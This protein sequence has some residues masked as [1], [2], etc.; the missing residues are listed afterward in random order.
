MWYTRSLVMR[1]LMLHLAHTFCAD[2][3]KVLMAEGSSVERMAAAAGLRIN[4]STSGSIGPFGPLCLAGDEDLRASE[5]PSAPP[6]A[7]LPGLG[8]RNGPYSY[9]RKPAPDVCEPGLSEIGG[10]VEGQLCRS[11]LSGGSGDSV[12]TLTLVTFENALRGSSPGW[13]S[14]RTRLPNGCSKQIRQPLVTSRKYLFV[15]LVLLLLLLVVVVEGIGKLLLLVTLRF[16]QKRPLA[17]DRRVE[18]VEVEVP[19]GDVIRQL[20]VR[21]HQKGDIERTLARGCPTRTA[22]VGK[23]RRALAVVM[24]VLGKRHLSAT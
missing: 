5:S 24:L 15:L 8:D 3:V 1:K 14:P 13:N 11:G 7:G 17:A 21:Q 23:F 10:L 18:H 19:F 9:A 2:S 22:K 4:P 20:L 16:D 12:G 6:D